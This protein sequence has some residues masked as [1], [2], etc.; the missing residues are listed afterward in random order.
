MTTAL[1]IP[2]LRSIVAICALGGSA[3][4]MTACSNGSTGSSVAEAAEASPTSASPTAPSS[5]SP[6][7]SL[8]KDQAERRDLL[9][10]THVSWDKAADTAVKEVSGG[11]LVSIELK[12]A[13]HG[14]TSSP[15]MATSPGPASPSPASPSPAS[16]S[17]ASPGTGTAS[18]SPSAGAAEW[19]TKV[20]AADGTVHRVDVD[21]ATGKVS[22]KA[23]EPDQ[24][25]GDKRKVAD[26]LK[27]VT[28]TPAQAVRTAT[29]KTK[30]TVTGV[31]LDEH[32]N[33]LVWAVDVVTPK[34]W[35]KT[36]YDIDVAN[37]NVVRE[38]VD[39]D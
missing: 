3:L 11:K 24:D 23:V 34:D 31:D 27:K 29:G 39:R 8:T 6:T 2:P 9:A 38:H 33:K 28:R 10:K 12:N 16:P 18:P 22:R 14:N 4:L 17:P 26:R 37:G 32:D 15:G 36:T 20:A 13:S 35:H 21:A 5:P 30:G 25:A 19:E 7:A 1:R